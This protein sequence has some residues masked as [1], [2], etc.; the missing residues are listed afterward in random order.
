MRTSYGDV[1]RNKSI[2]EKSIR[3]AEKSHTHKVEGTKLDMENSGE[4]EQNG[5]YGGSMFL[6]G[7]YKRAES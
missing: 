1:H 2:Q 6:R 3:F 5:D 7:I 4:R